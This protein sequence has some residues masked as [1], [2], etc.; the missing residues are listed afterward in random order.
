MITPGIF[1]QQAK[2]LAAIGTMPI[3]MPADKGYMLAAVVQSAAICLDLPETTQAFCKEFVNGFCDRYR[4]QMP[5]VIKAI[6]DAWE[7]PNLMTEEEFEESLGEKWQGIARE[8]EQEMGGEVKIIVDKP[9]QGALCP[10]DGEPCS[11]GGNFYYYPDDCPAYAMCEDVA[12]SLDGDKGDFFQ[13][14]ADVYE[15]I[16]LD[17]DDTLDEVESVFSVAPPNHDPETFDY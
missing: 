11:K 6:E 3:A 10:V 12:S 2:E 9:H 8:V 14:V 7:N 15:G 1:E 16:D 4:D 17:D 5:T 13:A